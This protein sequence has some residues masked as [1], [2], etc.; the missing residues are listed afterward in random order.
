MPVWGDLLERKLKE[1]K[2]NHTVRID[3]FGDKRKKSHLGL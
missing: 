3:F 1:G 2:I